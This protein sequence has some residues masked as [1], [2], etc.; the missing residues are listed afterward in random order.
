V[1]FGAD[2]LPQNQNPQGGTLNE[3]FYRPYMGYNGVPQQIFQGT[4][5]YHSLQAQ[6]HRRFARSLQFGV[7]YTHSKAMDY[8]EGDSTTSQSGSNL[9][10]TYLNRKIWNYGIA[11]YDRPNILTFHFLYDVPR[12]SR[13][14]PNPVVKALFDGWQISDITTFESGAPLGI[15]MGE[16]PTVNITGSSGSSG[17][18]D[19]PRPLMVGNPNGRA[20]STTGTT[21][22][23]SP[24]RF[25]TRAAS[26]PPAD[27]RLSASPISATCR[28][29]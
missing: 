18:G 15:T 27:A 5:S 16:S 6:V 4:S 20:R 28:R 23:P 10:S 17:G 1:P 25:S 9:V 2:F 12:L 24:S 22:R 13:V 14:L 11:N 26:A 19:N 7:V 21:C 3:N 29:M 8:A